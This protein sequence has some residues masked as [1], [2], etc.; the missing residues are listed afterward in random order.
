MSWTDPG[1]ISPGIGTDIAGSPATLASAVKSAWSA[2]GCS[3]RA[4]AGAAVVGSN[5]AVRVAKTLRMTL[6][7]LSSRDAMA[8]RFPEG[9]AAPYSSIF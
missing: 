9:T 8:A 6:E 2:G 1:K 5:I 7:A 4:K 3:A